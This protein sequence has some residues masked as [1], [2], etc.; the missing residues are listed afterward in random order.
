MIMMK[1]KNERDRDRERER[2]RKIQAE[3]EKVCQ[4]LKYN[5]HHDAEHLGIQ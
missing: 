3:A 2:E 1:G 5:F 4:I